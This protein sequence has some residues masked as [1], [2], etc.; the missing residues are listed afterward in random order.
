MASSHDFASLPKIEL[1]QWKLSPDL[2]A[3][4]Q[5]TEEV[6]ALVRLSDE[7]LLQITPRG[8][9][10][11]WY[12]GSLPNRGGVLIDMR[13]MNR[14][15]ALDSDGPTVAAEGGPAREKPGGIL[16]TKGVALP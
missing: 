9:G 15:L 4:P 3:L 12:G 13:K 16:R 6:A 1:L 11:G 7:S 2:V 5:T 8:G 10:T 14:V